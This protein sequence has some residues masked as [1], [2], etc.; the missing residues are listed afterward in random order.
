M[1]LTTGAPR[2]APGISRAGWI[3]RHVTPGRLSLL[4]LVVAANPRAWVES[5]PVPSSSRLTTGLRHPCMR[6]DA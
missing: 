6:D 2:L 5:G 1:R 3:L 4:A